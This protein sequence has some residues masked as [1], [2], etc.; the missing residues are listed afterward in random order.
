M[1]KSIE[2]RKKEYMENIEILEKEIEILKSNIQKAKDA[3]NSIE[4]EE[5]TVIFD[6]EHNLE[7]GLQIISLCG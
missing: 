3:L 2:E 5:D 6:M 4:T 1:S 7:E